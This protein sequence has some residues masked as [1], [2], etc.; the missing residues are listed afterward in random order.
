MIYG[1]DWGAYLSATK[2]PAIPFKDLPGLAGD[3]K[4]N[5]RIGYT[6]LFSKG[7]RAKLFRTP[8]VIALDFLHGFGGKFM[9]SVVVAFVVS[10]SAF[11]C[12]VLRI[13][14]QGSEKKMFRITTSGIIAGVENL[15]AVRY[16]PNRKAITNAGRNLKLS[17]VPVLNAKP[18]VSFSVAYAGPFPTIVRAALI[19]L[20][21]KSFFNGFHCCY[22]PIHIIPHLGEI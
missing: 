16:F 7:N 4:R 8:Y 17:L 9:P 11:L 1:T 19:N 10:A 3:Y 6:I 14:F 5:C 22:L 12:S 15:K 18:A 21:P 20:F 13:I 2:G